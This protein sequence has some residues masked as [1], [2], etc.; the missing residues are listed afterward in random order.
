MNDLAIAESVIFHQADDATLGEVL[1][2]P[3]GCGELGI[4]DPEVANFIIYPNPA[5]N[6]IRFTNTPAFSKVSI[7]NLQ[8]K[9]VFDQNISIQTQEISFN[10]P[11]GVYFARFTNHQTTIIKK[12]LVQ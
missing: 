5:Q 3:V 8:G 7:V 6:M 4:D 2:D 10:V 11:S 1:Y 9:I 12:L